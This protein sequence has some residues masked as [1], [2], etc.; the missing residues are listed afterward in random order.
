M[1]ASPYRPEKA[2]DRGTKCRSWSSKLGVA[3]LFII[4]L[5]N[6][7]S[8]VVRCFTS[9]RGS[10]EVL[11]AVS[12]CGRTSF[13]AVTTC[14]FYR[15]RGDVVEFQTL[16]SRSGLQQA[17]RDVLGRVKKVV[18]VV[19]VLAYGLA[20]LGHEV[21]WLWRYGAIRY[22]KTQLYGV[23]PRWLGLSPGFAAF[24]ACLDFTAFNVSVFVPAVCIL[25]Y[26]DVCD[27]A[28]HQVGIFG[29]WRHY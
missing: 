16:T 13:S 3:L 12:V 24:L 15:R 6:M 18:S 2:E 11:D 8:T 1:Q 14:L 4:F 10:L 9:T 19:L 29:F 5:H 7:A 22:F 23:D 25:R 21:A 27:L 26:V 28:V 17:K 20:M